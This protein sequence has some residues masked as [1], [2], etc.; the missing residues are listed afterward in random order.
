MSC[1]DV[2]RVID[3]YVDGEL[4]GAQRLQVGSHLA[5]CSHCAQEESALRDLGEMLRDAARLSPQPVEELNGLAG[6]VVSRIGAEAQQSMGAKWSRVSE[7]WHWVFVGGGAFSA[8]FVAA[9]FV[10]V[11]LYTPATE[12]RQM[13]ETVGTLCL[14]AV[15]EDGTGEPVMLAYERELGTA[16]PGPACSVPASIGWKGQQALVQA[17][18][19]SLMRD[20]KLSSFSSLSAEDREEVE[21]ILREIGRFHASAPSRRPAGLTHV[22]G[23]HLELNA[24][25]TAAGL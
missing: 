22:S 17:L 2:R 9:L 25:V 18:E 14:M 11:A 3:A 15:P 19:T 10:F 20:G 13:G 12:A 7:D 24:V 6:G 16:R 5:S 1:L 8:A 4:T 23:M 21:N